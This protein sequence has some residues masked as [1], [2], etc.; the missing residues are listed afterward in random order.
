MDLYLYSAFLVLMTTQSSLQYS[1]TFTQS[2]TH[3][4][5]LL[6]ALCTCYCSSTA[7][8]GCLNQLA[9]FAQFIWVGYKTPNLVPSWVLASHYKTA[10]C[11]KPLSM[12]VCTTSLETGSADPSK[13][14]IQLDPCRPL[15]AL[16]TAVIWRHC[17][18]QRRSSVDTHTLHLIS[19]FH[20]R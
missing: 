7:Q 13:Q 5:H 4:V 3:T 9:S 2:H 11:S 6:A 18:V 16:T 14:V 12:L 20:K 19:H 15:V 1:F 10:Q 8:V 17:S